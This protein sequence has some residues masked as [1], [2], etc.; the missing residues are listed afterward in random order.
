[1]GFLAI[2]AQSLRYGRHTSGCVGWGI[3]SATVSRAARCR[4]LV[5][6]WAF[7]GP[8]F[9]HGAFPLRHPTR[10]YVNALYRLPPLHTFPTHTPAGEA[11]DGERLLAQ[12]NGLFRALTQTQLVDAVHEM[13]ECPY[14]ESLFTAELL[15][16]YCDLVLPM[17][18]FGREFRS[19]EVSE[20][21]RY[22]R[23]CGGSGEVSHLLQDT[24][25]GR[26]SG[27]DFVST[28]HGILM[29]FGTPRTNKAVAMSLAGIDAETGVQNN[30]IG[31]QNVEVIEMPEDS[32]PLSDLIAFGGQRTFFYKDTVH[33]RRALQLAVERMPKLNAQTLKIE[34]GCS[35]LSHLCGVS[36]VYDVMC[37]QDFPL[38]I[39]RIGECG[40]NPF[41]VEWS[42]PRKLGITM[43]SVCLIA[44]FALGSLNGGGYA[45][46]ATPMASNTNYHSKD[47]SKNARLFQGGHR[48]YGDQGA[49][50]EAQIRSGELMDVVYQRP[51]RYRP[52]IHGK[53]SIVQR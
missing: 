48:I 51:P 17:P 6:P 35:I 29:G 19:A 25:G 52:P 3:T 46:S 32:A 13:R 47:A 44:R 21:L 38:S 49:P 53:G 34:P 11:V 14:F 30:A 39:E 7:P 5:R 37:D 20:T 36:P 43:P 8:S 15:F 1:M 4:G 40:M 24:K 45:T 26:A 42:E 10:S 22:I 28:T 18:K 16:Q 50:L 31:I 27:M 12:I 9:H 33:G 41:P 23:S 2:R